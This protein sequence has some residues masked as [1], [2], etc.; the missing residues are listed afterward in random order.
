MRRPPEWASAVVLADAELLA[1]VSVKSVLGH[2]LAGDL[3]C[4]LRLQAPFFVDMGKL[5]PLLDRSLAKRAPL[6]H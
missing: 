6:P 1:R 2:E 4:E 3:L 5:L